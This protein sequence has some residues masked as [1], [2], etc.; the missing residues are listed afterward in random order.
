MPNSG[1]NDPIRWSASTL[2]RMPLAGGYFLAPVGPDRVASFT[3]EFRATS[4]FLRYVANSHRVPALT[5]ES[6]INARG[7]LAYWNAGAVVVPQRRDTELWKKALPAL[8]GTPP[9]GVGDV[10]LWDV[11]KLPG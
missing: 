7:D 1:V 3:S 6:R 9:D 2:T 8:S 4:Y 5:E 11:A 10:W